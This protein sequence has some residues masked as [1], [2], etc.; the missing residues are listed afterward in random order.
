M[1]RRMDPP[2]ESLQRAYQELLGGLLNCAEIQV[3]R[4]QN[5]RCFEYS[6]KMEA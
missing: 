2:I 6:G 4:K 5:N 3:G 1:R